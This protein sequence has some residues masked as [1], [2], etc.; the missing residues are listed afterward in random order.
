M[1][2]VAPV[3]KY[4]VGSRR[5]MVSNW[6]ARAV[7]VGLG[8]CGWGGGVCG[9]S[10]SST[11]TAASTTTGITPLLSAAAAAA[12]VPAA[13]RSTATPEVAAAGATV[14]AA[15]SAGQEGRPGVVCDALSL[16][17]QEQ[18]GGSGLKKVGQRLL[19]L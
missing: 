13:K 1:W 11:S 6:C 7:G 14:W 2:C 9:V 8:A 10:S 19:E 15:G 18:E 17:I 3:S 16:P 4:H 12:A 5:V